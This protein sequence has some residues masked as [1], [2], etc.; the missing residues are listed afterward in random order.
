MRTAEVEI[1]HL[2]YDGQ[3]VITQYFGI[4]DRLADEPAVE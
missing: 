2:Q 4:T 1:S 3:L